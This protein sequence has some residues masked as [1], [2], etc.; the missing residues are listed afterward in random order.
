VNVFTFEESANQVMREEHP[1]EELGA[2][3]GRLMAN[4]PADR[5]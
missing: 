4:A 1:L 5:N 2:L 3:V